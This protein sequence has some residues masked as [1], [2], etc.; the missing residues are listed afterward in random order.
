MK[1]TF[2]GAARQVTGSMFLLELKDSYKILIDCGTDYDKRHFNSSGKLFNF[3]PAELD[4]VLLTH[5][6]LDHSGN[7]PLLFLN[8][9]KGQVLCTAATLSLVQILLNDSASINSRKLKKNLQLNGKIRYAPEP[10]L[11]GIYLE[12]QVDDATSRF[13][14]LPFNQRFEVRKG[15]WVNFIPTGHLLGAANIVIEAEEDGTTK[16][17][18]FSGDVGRANYPLLKDPQGLPQVDYLVCES[19]YGNRSHE[20]ENPEQMLEDIIKQTCVDISGRLIIPAFSTGRTQSLLFVLNKLHRQG[21]LPRIKTFADSPM[22]FLSTRVYGDYVDLMNEEA[23]DFKREYGDLFDFDNL[24]QIDNYKD[25]KAISDY[26]EPCIIISS[27]GMLAGGRMQMHVKKN[28]KNPYST[29]LLVGYS[30]EGTPGY[31]L[32]TGSRVLKLK[33][34]S[35]PVLANVVTTDVFSGHADREDLINFV[36]P[37]KALKKVFLVHGEQP[38]LEAFKEGLEK[39]GFNNVVI[40]DRGECFEL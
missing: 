29:I 37:Q 8:G 18:A 19:T 2:W 25:S 34:K 28:I 31:D 38:S 36:K 35:F 4:L 3:N 6:H 21:R 39:E 7:I 11:E 24:I 13:V 22:A 12:K 17:I 33:G 14:T 27:S 1:L 32:L 16:K 40:P 9:Y 10:A 5:A 20:D 30:A 23:Q 26:Y 15:L